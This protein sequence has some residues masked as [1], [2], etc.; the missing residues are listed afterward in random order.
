MENPTDE[1]ESNPSRPQNNF[2]R[3][4]GLAF[5]ML[6]VFGLAFW[7]GQA[8][9]RYWELNFPMVTISLLFLAVVGTVVSLIKNLPKD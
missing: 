4:S 8:L 2:L 9:D 7:G 5:Q 3:F 1:P 6:A